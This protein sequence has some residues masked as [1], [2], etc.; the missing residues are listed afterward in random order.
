MQLRELC[1]IL[2]LTRLCVVPIELQVMHLLVPE[3]IKLLLQAGVRLC[4]EL[5]GLSDIW[6]C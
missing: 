6:P 4:Q 2:L 3:F 5:D 1:Y